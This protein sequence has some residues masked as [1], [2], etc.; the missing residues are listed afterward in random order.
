MGT[1]RTA[2]VVGS[3]AA[4]ALL[5]YYH[6]MLRRRRRRSHRAGVLDAKP[7]RNFKLLLTDTSPRPFVHLRR[8]DHT[9][10]TDLH[11]YHE[12]I[13]TLIENLRILPT[14]AHT[15]EGPPPMTD[16]CIWID[17]KDELEKLAEILG[18]ET[19][20]GVDTEQ[21]S[22]RSF[23]GFTALLQVSTRKQDFLIDAI[24]LHDDMGILKKVFADPSI[25]KV[26]HGADGDNLWLQ[27][28]FHIYIINLFDTAK[29]CEVLGKRPK[30]LAYLLQHY[31][32]VATNKIFQRAD[33][34]LRPLPEEMIIYARTDAHYLLYIADCL[35]NE[36]LQGDSTCQYRKN[37]DISVMGSMYVE[38]VRRCNLMCM[39]LYEKDTTS[40][41][42]IAVA[43]L[44][45]HDGHSKSSI[46]DICD[47][48]KHNSRFR[49]TVIALCE[50]RDS[51][52]R[53]AD[54]S[55]RFLLSD[56]AILALAE[57][58]PSNTVSI[59]KCVS[60]V[61]E[62]APESDLSQYMTPLPSPSPVLLENID[63][64]KKVLG[65]DGSYQLE[66]TKN[67]FASLWNFLQSYRNGSTIRK[68]EKHKENQSTQVHSR[69]AE[70]RPR[71]NR[72][73][74]DYATFRRN[75]VRK[76]SCKGP[77]YQNCRIYAGDGGLLCFCDRKK[78]DWYVQ[79]GLAEFLDEDPPAIKLLFEPK[80]RPEDENNDFYLQSKT[81]RCVGCGETSHYLRYRVIPSCYRMYFPQHL[82]SH[83]SHDIVLLCV[84]CHE[85]AHSAAE[86]HKRQVALE[87]GIPLFARR[88]LDSG[89]LA[90]SASEAQVVDSTMGGVSP[91]PLRTAAVAL[92]RYGSAM[93]KDRREE[94]EAVVQAYF[95]GRTISQEDIAAAALVGRGVRGSSR[96]YRKRR[97][98]AEKVLRQKEDAPGDQQNTELD[99][100]NQEGNQGIHAVENSSAF[101][102]KKNTFIESKALQGSEEKTLLSDSSLSN[103][104]ESVLFLGHENE[105]VSSAN[106]VSC[107]EM[108]SLLV[109]DKKAATVEVSDDDEQE[110]SNGVLHAE[111]ES[112]DICVTKDPDE[113]MSS[114]GRR[115][116][117]RASL[118]GHGPHGKKVVEM[119][120]ETEGDNGVLHFC[121]MWRSVFVESVK[122]THL[123]AGWDI[124]HSGHR[125]FG[126]YSI[127]KPSR[128]Q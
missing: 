78:L 8:P 10:A 44:S 87:Y 43:L 76:F 51:V 127:Y 91:R 110:P 104:I 84:D 32:G 63:S 31:C 93:P 89:T 120:L 74:L 117:Q 61:S 25:C 108:E 112:E 17:T 23:L 116:K 24:A 11:P 71:K 68:V 33:W 101:V 13:S 48:L 52:A 53:S 20:F 121:Q 65:K 98:T 46:D 3:I 34:R 83:R 86:K 58:N 62:A 57:R 92:L 77:V 42:T 15:R 126:E 9:E 123:P 79:R 67:H 72:R 30:S 18:K 118:L 95:G 128:K 7:Q 49:R 54:E 105:I 4:T 124:L 103:D 113:A 97:L 6:S 14:V 40:P 28:D 102:R 59:L 119:L 12:E 60:E 109:D 26:F 94:L 69:H 36:L 5:L 56:Q 90:G 125:D 19:E 99:V 96:Q 16:D 64:L 55:P 88:V 81:N 82:K 70:Q 50:W 106:N 29:A 41:A 80:R 27:K 37:R 45:R 22:I 35:R 100:G 111:S 2:M 107:E 66:L 38:C 85:I 39:Q 122:P 114:P 1:K 73:S 75:F 47:R 21:H 115:Q